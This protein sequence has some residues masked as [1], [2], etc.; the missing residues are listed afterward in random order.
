M[1]ANRLVVITGLSGSGKSVALRTFED[2]G[3]FCVDNLPAPLIPNFVDF[4][5]DIPD[6]W[7]GS[8]SVNLGT[9]DWRFALCI[10]GR[11]S[12]K[13]AE[14]TAAFDRL[15]GLGTE[16]ITLFFDSSDE[17][18]LRRFRETRR[19]H[20]ISR[21]APSCTSLTEAIAREREILALFRGM[22]TRI[23]D[24]TAYSP[25]DLRRVV[26]GI[27]QHESLLEISVQSFGFK[28]GAPTDAD[29]VFDVRFLPNPHFVAELKEF[30]G[31]DDKVRDFV[32]HCNE[33]NEFLTR[34][35]SLLDFVI[36]GYEREGKRYLTIAIGC[37]GGKHRSVALV[38][39][40]A[41]HLSSGSKLRVTAR[42]RDIQK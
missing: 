29:L 4:L 41:E 8:K 11:E 23:V 16:L 33:T 37:T 30:T 18:I 10:D 36:P 5:I 31:L 24:T 17:V 19:V 21:L 34:L 1:R 13:I 26:E 27:F 40:V 12:Y 25:H 42:H 35:F 22:A 6:E 15:T 2:M 20:P 14:V 7:D 9:R 3:Y 39:R 28:Y 32:F 38:E